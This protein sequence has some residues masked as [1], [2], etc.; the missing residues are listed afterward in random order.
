MAKNAELRIEL[1]DF[2]GMELTL[3]KQF[4]PEEL[5]EVAHARVFARY[6][7]LQVEEQ[8]FAAMRSAD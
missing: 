4:L 7:G 6:I 1:V 5:R 8:I 2:N 3:T